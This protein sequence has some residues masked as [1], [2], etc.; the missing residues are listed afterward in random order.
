MYDLVVE[1]ARVNHL[2]LKEVYVPEWSGLFEN[3]KKVVVEGETYTPQ[4]IKSEECDLIPNS[5]TKLPWREKL[6]RLIP[7]YSSRKLVIVRKDQIKIYQ[8]VKDLAGK[9]AATQK[10]T[11]FATWLEGQNASAF[12]ANPVRIDY[13]SEQDQLRNVDKKMADFTI[14]DADGALYAVKKSYPN[15]LVSLAI[16]DIDELCWATDRSNVEL[17]NSVEKFFDEQKMD[18]KSY[19]NKVWKKYFDYSYKDYVDV[20]SLGLK[21]AQ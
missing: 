6:L 3:E 4:I 16:G 14:Y 12:K 2:K 10:A 8:K 13:V 17:A 18:P 7:A 9:R 1:Y 15:L 5:I 19:L 20:I 11:S 21:T